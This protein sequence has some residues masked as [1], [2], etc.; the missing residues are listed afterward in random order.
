MLM[1][2]V[3]LVYSIQNRGTVQIEHGWHGLL[4]FS[5]IESASIRPISVIRVPL[6]I[7][8]YGEV[9]CF[10]ESPSSL[11]SRFISTTM[12]LTSAVSVPL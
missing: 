8:G 3:I 7:D 11:S 5:R 4:R 10:F 9:Y 12:R 6:H 1:L 2:S